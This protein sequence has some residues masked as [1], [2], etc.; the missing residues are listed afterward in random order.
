MANSNMQGMD[1]EH[2]R[3]VSGQMD[4]HAGQV[5]GV[6]AALLQRVTAT[7]WTGPD[8]DRI[9][10]DIGSSFLPNANAA[11]ESINEQAGYLRAKADEQ[12]AV[13]S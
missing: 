7:S 11:C 5:A 1:T 4:S 13:S 8:K 2:A 9:T 6:C 12:D 3:E 10:D